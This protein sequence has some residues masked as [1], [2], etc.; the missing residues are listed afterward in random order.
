MECRR[1]LFRRRFLFMGKYLVDLLFLLGVA[2]AAVGVWMVSPA[3]AFVVVGVVL[4][5]VALA[6]AAGKGRI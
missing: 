3:A 6:L 5:V 2:V 1:D 4:M